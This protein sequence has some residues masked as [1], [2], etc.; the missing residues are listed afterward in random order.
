[1]I[2]ACS[3]QA[4]RGSAYIL[5][6]LLCVTLAAACSDDATSPTSPTTQASIEAPRASFGLVSDIVVAQPLSYWQCPFTPPYA[7]PFVVF[8]QRDG[9]PRLV[10]TQ[11]QLRFTDT[12]GMSMPMIT[13]PAPVP[14]TQFGSALEASRGDLRFPLSMGIGCGVGRSGTISVH[15]NTRDGRGRH[16][17][18]HLSV[19]VR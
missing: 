10:V 5:T 7:V 1:M 4:L 6:A 9:D 18:G 15:F 16:G 3:V 12:G 8:V 19:S 14:T 13:L 17:S 2:N 11:F